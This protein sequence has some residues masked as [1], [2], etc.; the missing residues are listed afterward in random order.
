MTARNWIWRI[1]AIAFCLVLAAGAPALSLAAAPANRAAQP[2]GP[3]ALTA[4]WRSGGPYGGD[5]R[6]LALSPEFASDGFALAGGWRT[7]R[8]GFTGGYGI[9]RTTDGGVTWQAAP[10]EQH[11]W[12]VFDLA[13]SPAV[14]AD[15]TVYAATGMG[16]LRS[17]DRGVTW[18]HLWGGLP[19]CEHGSVCTVDRVW[20]SP[21]FAADGLMLALHHQGILYRSASRGDAWTQALPQVVTA[22]GFVRTASGVPAILAAQFDGVSTTRL[23]H[24][25][26]GGATWAELLSL[27][28]VQVNDLLQ[29][30]EGTWLLATADGVKRLVP[31]AGGYTIEAAAP[32]IAGPVSRLGL[33]GDNAYA[34]ANAGLY[35]SLSF[36][37]GW[38]RYADTPATPFSAVAPCPRWGACHALM[39]GTHTGLIF[40]PDD[41]LVPWRWLNGPEALDVRGVSA[42]P[43]Y[44]GDGVLFAATAQGIFRTAD[45]GASWQLLLAGSPP[46]D[47]YTFSAIQVSPGYVSDGTV[48]AAYENQTLALSGLYKTTDRGATWKLLPG[49]TGNRSLT[50]SPAYPSDH[51]VF[52]GNSDRLYKSTDGGASWNSYVIAPPEEGFILFELA[53]SPAYA[54]DRTLFATGYG[55]VLRSTDGGATWAPVGGFGPSYG[56]ALSPNYAADG[57]AW[58]TYRAI[59]SAGDGTPDSGVLRTTDRGAIW[60]LATAGLP[61]GYEPYPVPLAV[62]PRY[63]TDKA[64]FTLLRG[65]FVSSESHS[66]HRALDGGNWWTDLGAAPGNPD[67]NDLAVTGFA[68]GWLTAHAATTAGVW[69]YEVACEERVAAGGFE[70]GAELDNFWQR[71]LTPA[72]AEFSLNRARTGHQSLRTGIDGASDVYSYSSANQYVTIPAGAASATLSFWWYPISRETALAA[73]AE[74]GRG[75]LAALAQALAGDA[76]D[77]VLSGDRQYALLLDSSGGILK[78]LMWT[79]SNARSWQ[80]A[81]FDLAAYRGSTVRIAF[82][83][84]NDGRDGSTA[85]YVDDVALAACWPAPAEPTPTP[86]VTPTLGPSLPRAYLPVILK[87]Y[88]APKAPTATPTATRTLTPVCTATPTAT[89]TPTAMPTA[90]AEELAARWLRALAI[91]PGAR[92]RLWGITNE[93]YLIRSGDRGA[94]WEYPPQP[95]VE[96]M[97]LRPSFIG[98]DYN[99]PTTLYLGAIAEGLWRS[100][101]GGL[102]WEKRHPIYAGPVTVGLDDPAVLWVGNWDSTYRPLARSDDGGLTWSTASQ[103]MSWFD[104]VSAPILIDPQAHNI[105]Y[106]LAVGAR[107][108]AFLYRSFDSGIWETLPAPFSLSAAAYPSPGL[109]LDSATR[110]LYVGSP[111]RTLY[112]SRNAYTPVRSEVSWQ[113]VHAFGHQPIPLAVGAGP[114]GAAL[115]VSL[116]DYTGDARAPGRTLRSDDGGAT[117]APLDIPPAPGEPPPPPATATPTAAPAA[118]PATPGAC[119]EGSANGGFETAEGWIIRAN[120]VLAAYVTA[121]VHGGRQS[122]RTGIP[123]GGANVLSYSPV[124]QAVTFPAAPLAAARL[125]FWRYAVNGDAGAAGRRLDAAALPR[126]EAALAEGV[127]AGDF[128]YLIAIHA[129]GAIDWL[130]TEGANAPTWRQVSVDVNRYRGQTIRFQL[131]TYNNGSSGISRT[132]VDDVALALCP[133]AGALVLPTGWAR[134]VVGRPG[135][136]TLYADVAG[137][138]YRSADAGATWRVSGSIFPEHA[139]LSGDPNMLYVG[140]GYPCYKGGASV[141]MWRSTDAG[142]SWQGWANSM[143]LKPL[144]AHSSLPWLYAADCAGP[145][146][147]TDAAW[148]FEHQHDPLFGLYDAKFLAPLGEDWA[149]VWA[150]GIS[151][152]GGGA[153]LVSRD[154]GASWAQSTPLYLDMGWLGDLKADRLDAG[155]VYAPALYGFFFTQDDGAT[156][157]QQTAGLADVVDPGGADRRYG[158]LALAQAPTGRLYLGTVRGL[159][160]RDPAEGAWHKITGAPFDALEVSDLLLL[161]AAAEDL[162]VT[163]P[164]GVYVYGVGGAAPAPTP[165]A[166]RTPAA[167]PTPIATPN[168]IPTA[169]PGAWPTP[170]LLATLNLPAGSHPHGVALSPAGDRAYVAFHGADHSGRELGIVTTSPLRLDSTVELDTQ[171]AGPNAV[172]IVSQPS[173]GPLVAVTDRQ[174]DEAL[175]IAPWGIHR[176]YSVGDMPDGVIGQGR[177]L[178]VANFGSDSVSIFDLNTLNFVS[179]LGVG[180]EPALF[181]GDPDT[182]D[183]YLSLHGSDKVARLHDAYVASEYSDIPAPYGLAFDPVNRRLYVA[184]RGVHH[185]VTVIDVP[186]GRVIGAIDVGAEPFVLAVNPDTGHL[187]VACGGRVKVYRTRD[188][189]PVATIPASAGAEEGIAVDA[190][191]DRVY[192]TSRDSDALT[193][194]QDAA[195]PLV[196]FASDRDRNSEIYSMLP[197]GREQ[198]RLTFTGD[199][200]ENDAAGSPDGRWIAF[201]RL[202]PEGTELWVMSRDGLNARRLTTGSGQNLHP[203]WSPDGTHLAFARFEAG[204]WDIHT[205]RLSDG[206]LTRLIPGAANDTAPDWSWATGRIAFGSDRTTSNGEIYTAAADGSDVRRPAANPSGD[207]WPSWSPAGDRLAFWGSRAE[208]TIYLMKADGTGIAPLLPGGMRP[209]GPHWGAAAGTQWIVFTGYRPDSGHSEVFRVTPDGSRLALLTLNDLDFDHATGWLPGSP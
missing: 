46:S 15:G 55:R 124:E 126:T 203:T 181:A 111:D 94:T 157:Q 192:V 91:E 175:L 75:E 170:Y 177:Y 33:A 179:T 133:P 135:S 51:T 173:L 168:A 98:M 113:A 50:L 58:Q 54:S 115:Y 16:L 109:M 32:D 63:A 48:F 131:G 200:G 161:D 60:S 117:W 31:G 96:G 187:F 66:L 1:G 76:P 119:Y 155:T 195:P 190:A 37:R 27:T 208:Q 182:N 108:T 8:Y 97:P 158:L 56:L 59:E 137:T 183:V 196:L 169:D 19:G 110:G 20:L 95:L 78:T 165:T 38:Q 160:A 156:W 125:S 44:A 193:V 188:W 3:A 106:N 141:T 100:M 52:V 185:K 174:T 151:E 81:T 197:D 142:V 102:T 191:S 201:T 36:G 164:N 132:F 186:T 85:M 80:R 122:M 40:T 10:D 116:N 118:P 45:R 199:I 209:S 64:L 43:G 73:E 4:G 65:Q 41:N 22:A 5:V 194:I 90:P 28:S 13:I 24:S 49:L 206:Y 153:V 176:R 25:V 53:A 130:Y 57:T 89:R 72:T 99:H 138:L 150:G 84:Y 34:A 30:G 140:D 92:S 149:T 47:A 77:E 14:A 12:P 67:A 26:D 107:G 6:A 159:Y 11:R 143:D 166:T 134:R 145:A 17:T 144:A 7:G 198:A 101:D 93:G 148:T 29:T 23:M 74:P 103:G 167:A 123:A 129:D 136:S 62:S 171:A 21:N 114:T 18:S 112:V 70:G 104:S 69:H 180:H 146:F 128:F 87:R 127:L 189:A 88:V 163:T 172:A 154:R 79:R 147:S 105:K 86:T 204:N 61:G 205:V 207:A 71:P 2:A 162:Y 83:V 82:G 152:G 35:I 121:P 184:S 120:P 39:A 68:T 139:V 178:Y 9:A 42:S 202:A